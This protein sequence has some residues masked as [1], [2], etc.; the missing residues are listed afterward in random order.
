MAEFL[1]Q[2]SRTKNLN[3]LSGCKGLFGSALIFLVASFNIQFGRT[4]KYGSVRLN[5]AP[6]Q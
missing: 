3:K 5:P 4:I 2:S 6:V 1:G